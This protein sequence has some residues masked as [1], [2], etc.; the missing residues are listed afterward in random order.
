MKNAYENRVNPNELYDVNEIEFFGLNKEDING[1]GKQKILVHQF[2]VNNSNEFTEK[3]KYNKYQVTKQLSTNNLN[4]LDI[5]EKSQ[6]LM[7]ETPHINT[8]NTT[9]TMTTTTIT[10][11]L[12]NNKK[13]TF[14]D[15]DSVNNKNNNNNNNNKNDIN[16]VSY[17]D[18]SDNGTNTSNVNN[19][20]NYEQINKNF[21]DKDNDISAKNNFLFLLY[22]NNY[23]NYNIHDEFYCEIIHWLFDKMRGSD[24]D[25]YM[26]IFKK[27]VRWLYVCILNIFIV[28][29]HNKYIVDLESLKK[30]MFDCDIRGGIPSSVDDGIFKIL[31]EDI[32]L[33]FNIII[34]KLYFNDTKYK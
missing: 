11:L 22:D 24:Q 1:N 29:S 8:T 3:N 18:I 23:V 12:K 17:V 34:A 16:E 14:N 21:S 28:L 15:I 27:V 26:I 25:D 10:P 9:M 32:K 2:L 31:N 33:L 20:F 6:L 30:L 19:T 13:R 4:N 5:L 7:I